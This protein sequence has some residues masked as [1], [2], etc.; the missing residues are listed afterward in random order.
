[1]KKAFFTAAL[2]AFETANT[3]EITTVPDQREIDSYIIKLKRKLNL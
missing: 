1:M 2:N 3:K